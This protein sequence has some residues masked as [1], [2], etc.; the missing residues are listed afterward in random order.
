MANVWARDRATAFYLGLG[1]AGLAA[2]AIGFSTTYIV[3]MARRSFSAP[4]I[5]HI[6]GALS[7]AW[8]I[9]FIAQS[10]L[11]RGRR[12][13]LHRR[14][15]L[16]GLPIALGILVS[17]IA[18]AL[19]TARRD[20]PTLGPTATSSII[21]TISALTIFAALVA[22]GI[23]FRH[24]PDWHKRLMLLA[25]VAVLWPAFFRFRHLLPFVPSP[26]IWL[27][28]VLADLPILIAAVRDRLVYGKIHPVWAIFGTA[29]VV[30]QTLEVIAFDSPAWRAV[31]A[32][33]Y[34]T[35]G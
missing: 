28:L 32:W 22:F 34:R 10:A 19:W 33:I 30:E 20:L 29:L 23:A 27:A 5:V 16:L 31:G 18:V 21:G 11:V 3:P 7:L 4:T 13:P 8:V 9:L 15:G 1:I 2:V 14:I 6:H 17:G 25:T 12:T 24:R 26:E 35:F